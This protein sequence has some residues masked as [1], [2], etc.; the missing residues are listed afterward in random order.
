MTDQE[1]DLITAFIARVAGAAPAQQ[2]SPSWGSPSVPPTATPLPPIDPEADALLGNLFQRYPEARYR[3]AQLAFVQEHALA[4]AQA[5]LAQQEAQLRQA[6]QQA[7]QAQPHG[8]FFS[9]LFG[10]NRPAPGPAMPPGPGPQAAPPPYPQGVPPMLQSS[11]PGFLGSALTTAAGVAGGMML[12]NALMDMF[13]SHSAAAAPPMPDTAWGPPPEAVD[14]SAWAVPDASADPG[15]WT[16]PSG[17]PT[18]GQGP[19]DGGWDQGD[20]GWDQG[21][22]DDTLV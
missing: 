15:S 12:G 6:A 16:D 18:A 19:G 13:S 2:S 1:R 10:G 5:R 14:P 3:L 8:G 17:D 21:G 4:A 20:S 22:G 9:G 7:Q 11:G